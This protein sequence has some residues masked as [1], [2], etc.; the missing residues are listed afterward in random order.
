MGF[1]R[2]TEHRYQKGFFNTF[3]ELYG[4]CSVLYSIV[5]LFAR[6]ELGHNDVCYITVVLALHK[7]GRPQLVVATRNQ[8]IQ[9][10]DANI[11]AFASRLRH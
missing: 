11:M 6:L 2:T 4:V 1:S 9:L 8:I 3:L 5:V 10:I 7:M